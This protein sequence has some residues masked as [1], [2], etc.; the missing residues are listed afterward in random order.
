MYSCLLNGLLSMACI[1]IPLWLDWAYNLVPFVLEFIQDNRLAIMLMSHHL[2]IGM[3]KKCPGLSVWSTSYEAKR[4][5][6]V[7][8]TR[9][10]FCKDTPYES[11]YIVFLLHCLW[12]CLTKKIFDHFDSDCLLK[13][14]KR[15]F[16]LFYLL[17][18][19]FNYLFWSSERR[20]N[21][22]RALFFMK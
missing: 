2:F 4:L 10:M 14:V 3:K 1:E 5:A 11:Y 6:S 15:I 22:F 17:I 8:K 16:F 9:N 13:L 20:Q 18:Y 7:K 12:A 21:H 19:L